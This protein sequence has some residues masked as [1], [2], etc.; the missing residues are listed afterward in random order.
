M[1]Q[2]QN[3]SH[4]PPAFAADCVVVKQAGQEVRFCDGFRMPAIHMRW[5]RNGHLPFGPIIRSAPKLH[6]GILRAS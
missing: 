2:F 5:P 6:G 1:A 3:P 4:R